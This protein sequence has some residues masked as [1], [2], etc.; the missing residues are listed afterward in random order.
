L[1]TTSIPKEN[2][3]KEEIDGEWSMTKRMMRRE[4]NVYQGFLRKLNER[5]VRTKQCL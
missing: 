2:E 4:K 5:Q 3:K 1:K